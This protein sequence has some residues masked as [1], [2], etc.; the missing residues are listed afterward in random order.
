MVKLRRTKKLQSS[1]KYILM[2]TLTNT[3]PVCA[4][5]IKRRALKQEASLLMHGNSA[6]GGIL[7][8]SMMMR[9]MTALPRE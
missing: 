3:Y 2:P 5:K 1:P 7:E 8:L 9:P 6:T 4:P